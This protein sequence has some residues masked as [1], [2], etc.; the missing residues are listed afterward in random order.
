MNTAQRPDPL[1]IRRAFYQGYHDGRFW[2]AQGCRFDA[3]DLRICPYS[4]F[5][6]GVQCR[7]AWKLGYEQAYQL[8]RNSW[9]LRRLYAI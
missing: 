3:H 8:G 6:P 5:M 2:R 4:T 7:V 1:R 9:S